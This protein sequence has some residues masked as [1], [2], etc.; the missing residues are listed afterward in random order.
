[1]DICSISDYGILE[2]NTIISL[3]YITLLYLL[4]D[5]LIVVL[6]DVDV[7]ILVDILAV[8]LLL[9]FDVLVWICLKYA[10]YMLLKVSISLTCIYEIPNS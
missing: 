6:M 1:M 9:L 10:E 3:F 2:S 8:V 7:D 5:V 4:I